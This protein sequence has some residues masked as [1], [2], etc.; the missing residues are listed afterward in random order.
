LVREFKVGVDKMND[1]NENEKTY[2]GA[3]GANSNPV[4]PTNSNV[5]SQNDGTKN[6]TVSLPMTTSTSQPQSNHRLDAIRSVGNE[7]RKIEE[8]RVNA[9]SANEK[10]MPGAENEKFSYSKPTNSNENETYSP[11][12]GS[13]VP[14]F[15]NNANPSVVAATEPPKKKNVGLVFVIA[16]VGALLACILAFAVGN[17]MGIFGSKTVIGGSTTLGSS[18]SSTITASDSSANLAEAVSTKCLPSVVSIDV[19]GTSSSSAT[20]IFDY[21]NGN[22]D[23]GTTETQTATGSGVIISKDGYI[24]TNEHVTEDGTSYK[25]NVNGKTLDAKLVGADSSSDVAVL[26]IDA[27]QDLTAVELG[28]SDT[29]RT[30]EWVMSIG[31]PFGLEQS[32]ATGII[33]ATSRSQI[34]D[35]SNSES[36]STKI[37]P[38]MIQTDAAINPGNSGGALVNENGQ[39]IGI[40]TLITSSSGNY[41]GVGFAIPVNYAIGI[42]RDLIEGKSP[43]YA[44]LGVSCTTITSSIAQR[45]GFDVSEGAYVSQVT[46]GSG[47]D[48]AGIKRGDIITEFEGEKVESSSDLTLDVRKKNPGDKVKVKFMRDN[49]EETVEVTLGKGS[50]DSSNSSQNKSSSQNQGQNSQRGLY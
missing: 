41:S 17:Y 48:N 15:S 8:E 5:S 35:S 46:S 18:T 50:S 39:L 36:S 7:Q 38:N 20:S 34:A 24:I 2:V 26:K 10:W 23:S 31:S 49:K 45:Y 25:I 21:L 47:A 22:M 14:P 9:N 40:N 1:N 29:I 12:S 3:Y 42:A 19:Y 44:Q 16:F 13:G 37:Y 4:S 28:D 30:G 11:K 32:V 33:S 6:L 27:G 43:T